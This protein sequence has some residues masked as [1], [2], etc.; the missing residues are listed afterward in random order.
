[1]GIGGI[2]I[3]TAIGYYEMYAEYNSGIRIFNF[4]IGTMAGF[5]VAWLAIAIWIGARLRRQ[6]F[7]PA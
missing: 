3:G 7:A 5:A 2:A 1:M 4:M 6:S